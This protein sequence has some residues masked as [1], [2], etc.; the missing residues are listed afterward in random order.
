MSSGACIAAIVA[1]S[2]S[3]C[4]VFANI[5]DPIARTGC[6]CDTKCSVKRTLA[7]LDEM[8][9]QIC[10]VAAD[11]FLMKLLVMYCTAFM[12][13]SARMRVAFDIPP[14]QKRLLDA[15]VLARNAD[16]RKTQQIAPNGK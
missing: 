11:Q 5:L 6:C 3:R 9:T 8:P 15:R 14:Q 2:Q 12:I 16:R 10:C 7:D 4:D 1:Q 13:V